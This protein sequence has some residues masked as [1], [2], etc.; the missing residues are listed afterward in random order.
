MANSKKYLDYQASRGF[1]VNDY[2]VVIG[3]IKDTGRNGWE[4]NWNPKMDGNVGRMGRII[5]ITNNGINISFGEG[6]YVWTYPAFLL[7]TEDEYYQMVGSS[8]ELS[9]PQFEIRR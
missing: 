2:V 4:I 6:E 5:R 7:I 9:E 8:E 3:T 1:N